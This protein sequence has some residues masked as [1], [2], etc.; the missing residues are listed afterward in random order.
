MILCVQAKVLI[1]QDKADIK[2]VLPTRVVIVATEF[3]DKGKH[4]LLRSF[5]TSRGHGKPHSKSALL[6]SRPTPDSQLIIIIIIIIIIRVLGVVRIVP[7]IF[8]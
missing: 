2:D 4:D 6:P 3:K 1:I 8:C 7:F 5:P